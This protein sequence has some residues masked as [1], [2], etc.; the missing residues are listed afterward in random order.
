MIHHVSI[1]AHDPRRV[2]DVLADLL[3]GRAYPFPGGIPGAY[4]AVSGDAHGTMIEVYPETTT[5]ELGDDAGGVAFGD[6]GGAPSRASAFHVLVSVPHER[7]AVERIGKRAGWR[8]RFLGRGA[9]GQPPVFHVIELWVENRFLIE[10]A[11]PSMVAAYTNTVQFAMLDRLFPATA[12]V[13]G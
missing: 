6:A 5:L 4:M 11:T 2:A 3:Q 8:T 12:P 13:L 10:V 1:P 7:E 9:P